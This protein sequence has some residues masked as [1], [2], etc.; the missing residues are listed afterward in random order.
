MGQLFWNV[1]GPPLPAE[2]TATPSSTS[3]DQN[4]LPHEHLSAGGAAQWKV[5][6]PSPSQLS[7]PVCCTGAASCFSLAWECKCIPRSGQELGIPGSFGTGVVSAAAQTFAVCNHNFSWESLSHGAAP[8]QCP[9]PGVSPS[10]TVQ[11]PRCR[12]GAGSTFSSLCMHQIKALCPPL[13]GIDPN[14]PLRSSTSITWSLNHPWP[15]AL[16]CLL[17]IHH[18]KEGTSSM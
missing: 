8:S 11:I 4:S 9:S 6:V 15:R 3:L 18:R 12:A 2:G 7:I 10:G 17:F 1:P 13:T 16:C 5:F 14:P